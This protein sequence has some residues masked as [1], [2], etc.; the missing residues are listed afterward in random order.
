MRIFL[1]D[2]HPMVRAGL[3]SV[4]SREK[5]VIE[6]KE[7]S[8]LKE[9]AELLNSYNP[10]LSIIDLRL[11]KEDGLEVI[12]LAKNKGLNT[13]FIVLTSSIKSEDF[14]RAQAA[15]VDG[16][17]LK[18]AF[19]EDILYAFHV[20]IRGKKYFTPDVLEYAKSEDNELKDLTPREKDV[21][22][23]LGKGLSN[24]QIAERL[25]IS[26][27]TVKKHISSILGKLGLNHRLEAA[28][29]INNSS[30]VMY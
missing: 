3:A 10:D 27:N 29:L 7:A 20:V 6:V 26:E 8:N 16:Y 5:E 22:L 12:K 28:V 21:L 24:M 19:I 9:A 2:D 15:G 17:I 4:L 18:D 30:K 25:Y 11:G 14:R 23:E 13:R 1:V